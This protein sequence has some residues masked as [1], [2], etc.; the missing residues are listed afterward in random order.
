MFTITGMICITINTITYRD[1]KI[2]GDTE[3]VSRA[4]H[5]AIIDHGTLGLHPATLDSHY[6]DLELPACI[7]IKK[8]VF[9]TIMIWSVLGMPCTNQIR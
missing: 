4:F 6:L 9:D 7:L 5:E 8:Y 1:G 3:A 2:T